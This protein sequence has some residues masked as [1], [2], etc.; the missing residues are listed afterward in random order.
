MKHLEEITTLPKEEKILLV[1]C[2][3]EMHKIDPAAQVI[4]YG[5]RARRDHDVDSD[6]DLLILTDGEAT[7]KKEDLFRR[8]IYDLELET[9]AVVTV[10]LLN[11]RTWT[12]SLYQVMPFHQNVEKD[13]VIL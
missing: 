9:G 6:Y 8:Q 5:S 4:L 1:Q 10:R 2:R 11:K 13:G 3:H 12:S 7:L